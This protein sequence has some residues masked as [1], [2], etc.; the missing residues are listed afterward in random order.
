MYDLGVTFCNCFSFLAITV[1]T[2]ALLK[3][4]DEGHDLDNFSHKAL[5]KI[6]SA[7]GGP[8]IEKFQYRQQFS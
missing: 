6:A 7:A 2:W 1:Q 5:C 4:L 3:I 8:L